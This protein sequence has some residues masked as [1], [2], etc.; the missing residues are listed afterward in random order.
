MDKENVIQP[1]NSV[2][3]GHKNEWS[4]DTIYEMDEPWKHDAKWKNLDSKEYIQ[5]DSTCVNYPE[6]VNPQRQK[7][8]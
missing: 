5:H 2:L 1:Y 6:E 3:F 8:D 7:V 4:S